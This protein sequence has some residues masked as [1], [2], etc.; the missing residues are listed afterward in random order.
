LSVTAAAGATSAAM[1]FDLI[2]G[3]SVATGTVPIDLELQDAAGKTVTYDRITLAIKPPVQ[4]TAK[5]IAGKTEERKLAVEVKNL[6]GQP[7]QGSVKLTLTPLANGQKA[8]EQEQSLEAPI[9]PKGASTVVFNIPGIDLSAGPWTATYATT[10]N[11]LT[12]SA[13]QVL[14]Q[15]RAW[16]IIGPFPDVGNRGLETATDV[17][18]ATDVSKSYTNSD[19]QTVS[20]KTVQ[21]DAAGFVNLLSAFKPN[22]NV[23]AYAA[24]WVKS[25]SDRS[26]Q[27]VAGA[28]D[29]ERVWV[30]GQQVINRAEASSGAGQDRA[31]VQLKV[32]WN[33]VL[34]KV[35]QASGGWGF[36]FELC[37]AKGL[38]LGDLI[39]SDKPQ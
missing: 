4:L 36:W 2:A 28:D 3:G 8:I 9:K 20:W 27:V 22:E 17:E 15:T 24:T 13:E 32:G 10:V 29:A 38:P 12:V 7:I 5:P 1:P 6:S 31:N 26:C 21:C 39:F 35:S 16:S 25:P 34:V 11:K 19:G 14:S 30:N 33:P 23:V 18:Q 37:D